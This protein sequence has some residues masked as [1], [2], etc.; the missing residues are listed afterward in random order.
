VII[1]GNSSRL[2]E[3]GAPVPQGRKTLGIA[4]VAALLLT[5]SQSDALADACWDRW[6]VRLDAIKAEGDRMIETLKRTGDC[7]YVMK[8]QAISN[9]WLAT[10]E[11]VPCENMVKRG[12]T[13]SD[14][15]FQ[16]ELRRFG[17]A[18]AA[19]RRPPGESD[20]EASSSAELRQGAYQQ[21]WC[22]VSTN[23]CSYRAMVRYK[24]NGSIQTTCVPPSRSGHATCASGGSDQMILE[25]IPNQPQPPPKCS[26]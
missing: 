25:A 15:D 11:A 9:K 7:S 3:W 2:R 21:K 6:R 1:G 13:Q 26:I 22:I 8:I 24:S 16:A 5:F 10:L 20:C 18:P 17:G 4:L 14:T 23:T 19:K 12:K